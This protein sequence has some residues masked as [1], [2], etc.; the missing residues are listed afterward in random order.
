MNP[1]LTPPHQGGT[2]YQTAF[3]VYEELASTPSSTSIRTLLGQAIT[4]LHL[5]RTPE[6]EAALNQA[7]EL[8]PG[9]ADVLANCVVLNTVLGRA[10]E[11]E[12]FKERLRGVRP[13]HI[14]LRGLEERRGAFESARGRWSPRFEVEA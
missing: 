1:S 5:G 6:A 11:A 8:A 4:E 12:A 3:Y 14:L 7:L 10:E 2:K 13:G 9:N